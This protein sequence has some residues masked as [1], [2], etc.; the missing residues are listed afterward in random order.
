MSTCCRECGGVL[1]TPAT[2]KIEKQV[3]SATAVYRLCH[4]MVHLQQEQFRVLAL[5]VRLRLIRMKTIAMGSLVAC[6]VEPREVF[7][8]AIQVGAHCVAVAHNH[9]SGDPS[10]SPEDRMLTRR[11][12]G[13]G[14]LV[15]VRLVDHVI[16][17]KN[18]HYSFRAGGDLS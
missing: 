16:V 6:P 15:G 17:A 8:F 12:H 7:R 1:Y 14:E 4:R 9:P 3:R 2:P 5:D 11:L 13:V 10:P 18:G